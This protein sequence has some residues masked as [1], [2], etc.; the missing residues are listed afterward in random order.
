MSTQVVTNQEQ[1][2]QSRSIATS[3]P[4]QQV[5]STH[6]GHINHSLLSLGT[7]NLQPSEEGL[8]DQRANKF[9]IKCQVQKKGCLMIIDGLS[10][11]K[12][13]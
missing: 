1:H 12:I 13:V 3:V 10:G 8:S 2:V 11:A 5:Q 6:N 9:F 7:L 4:P